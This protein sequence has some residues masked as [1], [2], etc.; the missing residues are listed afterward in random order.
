[1]SSSSFRFQK[2]QNIKEK[3]LPYVSGNGDLRKQCFAAKRQIT[4]KVGQLTN[5]RQEITRIVSIRFPLILS[6]SLSLSHPFLSLTYVFSS[7]L[8]DHLHLR[9]FIL[10]QKRFNPIR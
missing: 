10:S 4:P 6:L 7:S 8:Q 1:L 5:S 3:V 9:S 2:Q